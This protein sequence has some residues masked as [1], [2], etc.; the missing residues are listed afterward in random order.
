MISMNAGCTHPALCPLNLEA[1]EIIAGAQ[2]QKELRT[3]CP[4]G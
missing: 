2:P 4:A 1:E 3:G